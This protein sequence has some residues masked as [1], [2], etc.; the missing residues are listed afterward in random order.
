VGRQIATA[1]IDELRGQ[2]PTAL[3]QTL[4]TLPADF[5]RDIATSIANGIRSRLA[6]L[7]PR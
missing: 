5:P 7:S 4:A 2:V 6:R 3:D 1:A